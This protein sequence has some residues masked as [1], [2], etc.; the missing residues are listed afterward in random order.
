MRTGKQLV[1]II[2]WRISIISGMA[3]IFNGGRIMAAKAGVNSWR[4][5]GSASAEEKPIMK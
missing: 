5:T 2:N 1:R 4:W 3:G